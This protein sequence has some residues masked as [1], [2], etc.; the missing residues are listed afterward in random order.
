[1]MTPLFASTLINELNFYLALCENA[2]HKIGNEVS[3]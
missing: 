3:W 1:M 2:V